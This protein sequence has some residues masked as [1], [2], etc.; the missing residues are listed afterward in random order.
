MPTMQRDRAPH[1]DSA[2]RM[3]SSRFFPLLPAALAVLVDPR[4]RPGASAVVLGVARLGR[5][6]ASA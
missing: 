2:G 4:R 3:L 6:L 5:A 1:R